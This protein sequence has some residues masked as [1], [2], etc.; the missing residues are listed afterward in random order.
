MKMHFSCVPVILFTLKLNYFIK[1]AR[2]EYALNRVIN[3]PLNIWITF[4]QL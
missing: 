2:K 4:H 3:I 1:I